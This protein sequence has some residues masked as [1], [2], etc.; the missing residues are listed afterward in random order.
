[1]HEIFQGPSNNSLKDF[2]KNGEKFQRSSYNNFAHPFQS[3]FQ[4][5]LHQEAT[6]Q[7]INLI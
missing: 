7:N 6:L 2:L 5:L 3:D 1:M 4:P